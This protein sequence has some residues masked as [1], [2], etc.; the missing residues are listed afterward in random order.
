[1]NEMG[2]VT[3]NSLHFDCF[4]GFIVPVGSDGDRHSHEYEV[5]RSSRVKW[6]INNELKE[7]R[8]DYKGVGEIVTSLAGLE[9]DL[10][11]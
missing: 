6:H 10:V 11:V 9:R 5:G 3:I 2:L 1:M 7:C 4:N 8:V